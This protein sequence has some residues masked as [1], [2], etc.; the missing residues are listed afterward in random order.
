MYQVQVRYVGEIFWS[1]V[2]FSGIAVY[3]LDHAMKAIAM[4]KS[5]SDGREIQ[6]IGFTPEVIPRKQWWS[7]AVE[8]K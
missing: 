5:E 8:E 3:R 6:L 4:E 1:K 2:Y 7:M